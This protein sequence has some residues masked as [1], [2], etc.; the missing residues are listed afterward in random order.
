MYARYKKIVFRVGL[1][2]AVA[3]WAVS[4][5]SWNLPLGLCAFILS[6][7]LTKFC[8]RRSTA[9]SKESTITKG[10]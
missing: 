3:F 4:V 7:Q 9:A 8:D 5:V 6:I 10:R 1:L 2:I